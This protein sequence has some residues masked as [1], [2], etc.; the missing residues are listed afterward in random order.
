MVSSHSEIE[1]QTSQTYE[2]EELQHKRIEHR[3]RNEFA[4]RI[5]H[6]RTAFHLS[7]QRVFQTRPGSEKVEIIMKPN[8][9]VLSPDLEGNDYL[10]RIRRDSRIVYVSVF[11]GDIIPQDH[12]NESFRILSNLSKVPRCNEQWT[13]FTVRTNSDGIESTVDEFAPHCLGTR[14]PGIQHPSYFN[15]LH[16]QRVSRISHRVSHVMFDGDRIAV[17]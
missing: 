4:N 5:L 2:T 6:A 3:P 8:E 1:P 7:Q 9:E 10:Y 11:H 12:R 14:A 17:L 13:T 15:I 16:L